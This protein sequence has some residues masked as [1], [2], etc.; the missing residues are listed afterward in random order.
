[1]GKLYPY[2]LFANIK[3][4]NINNLKSK[5]MKKFVLFFA[6]L[7]CSLASFATDVV[8]AKVSGSTVNVALENE[9]TYCAFQMDI[10]LPTGKSVTAAAAV[11]ERLAQGANVTINSTETETPFVVAYNCIDATNNVWRVIAY[12]LGNHEIQNKTGDI[13]TLTLNGDVAEANSVS[14]ANILF[15]ATSGLVEVD[16]GTATG[17]TGVK[18]GDVVP[19]G[20]VMIND[21]TATIDLMLIDS[22]SQKSHATTNGWIFEA[23]DVDGNGTV[24]INDVVSVIDLFLNDN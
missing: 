8:T 22:A 4:N 21:V 18:P 1:M 2:D 11:T 14:I 3:I 12:N 13:L 7:V 16:L 17:V 5:T 9:T 24:M 20:R 19:N 10:T 23:A 6:M 15:V